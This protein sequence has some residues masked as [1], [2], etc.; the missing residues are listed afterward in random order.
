MWAEKFFVH[1]CIAY[2]LYLQQ[3]TAV[4]LSD[5]QDTQ[6]ADASVIEGNILMAHE[7]LP[8]DTLSTKDALRVPV[9]P[10]TLFVG[11]AKGR[12]SV[13]NPPSLRSTKALCTPTKA[14]RASTM[15]RSVA[16]CVPG[17]ELTKRLA[18][19]HRPFGCRS[20]RTNGWLAALA[21]PKG[22]PDPQ[23]SNTTNLIWSKI[24]GPLLRYTPRK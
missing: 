14:N 22:A 9:E 6:M 13:I 15:T 16:L 23:K 18:H 3:A 19:K 12:W 4:S 24:S 7:H 10:A 8:H 17:T 21:S 20:T 5:K 1:G 2:L 11:R